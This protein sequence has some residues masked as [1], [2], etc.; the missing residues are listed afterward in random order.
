MLLVN[1]L[2]V[3][4]IQ[5][6]KLNMQNFESSEY[7]ASHNENLNQQVNTHIDIEN[8]QLAEDNYK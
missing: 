4:K 2:V 8:I 7:S 3:N 6:K 5:S 1:L